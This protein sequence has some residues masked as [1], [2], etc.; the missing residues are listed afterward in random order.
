[1]ADGNESE[2]EQSEIM[3]N[4]NNN[5]EGGDLGD[6]DKDRRRRSRHHIMPE[7]YTGEEDWD[8]YIEFFEDCAELTQ[9]TSQEK[10]LY[11]TTSLKGKARLF[12]SSL[13]TEEKRSYGFLTARLEQRF[14]GKRQQRRWMAKLQ[15]RTRGKEKDIATFG[16]EVRVLSQRAYGNL[17]QEAQEMLALQHFYRNVSPEMRCSLCDNGCRT[18]REAVEVVERVEDVM[19]RTYV[20][21]GRYQQINNLYTTTNTDSC[22]IL[23]SNSTDDDD[24]KAILNRMERRMEKLE[25]VVL[26]KRNNRKCYKCG[27]TDHLMNRCPLREQI[28]TK[29]SSE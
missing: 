12:Y 22:R 13:P 27:S 18:I 10:L 23:Q 28:N 6:N 9:W 8:Q 17:D 15:T 3:F 24:I 2:S 7:P 20:D 5:E 1:M 19:G 26:V 21:V 4:G 11:L 16:D 29:E 14:S 25:A